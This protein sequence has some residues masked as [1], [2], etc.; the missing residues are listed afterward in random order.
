MQ[1]KISNKVGIF[2]RIFVCLF[3]KACRDNFKT[4]QHQNVLLSHFSFLKCAFKK[5]EIPQKYLLPVFFIWQFL[6]II[7]FFKDTFWQFLKFYLF[8]SSS[9]FFTIFLKVIKTLK[10]D[11]SWLTILIMAVSMS[12]STTAYGALTSAGEGHSERPE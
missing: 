9:N 7:I 1:L 8:F 6:N 11:F 3:K 10:T 2:V 12:T 4:L 5:P